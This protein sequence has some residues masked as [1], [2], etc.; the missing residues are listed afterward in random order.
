VLVPF[1]VTLP[2]RLI[3]L[4]GAFHK[5]RM[6][7]PYSVF[8]QNNLYCPQ[9]FSSWIM[10]VLVRFHVSLKPIEIGR[11]GTFHKVRMSMLPTLFSQKQPP[12]SPE[13]FE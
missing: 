2:P 8:S 10:G 12:L 3:G 9:R 4:L 13:A 1:D 11:L 5:S 7:M 6:R